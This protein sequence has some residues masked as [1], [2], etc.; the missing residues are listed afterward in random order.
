MKIK[1]KKEIR[2]EFRISEDGRL[3]IN[4]HGA[5]Q[6]SILQI[7]KNGKVSEYNCGTDQL[8]K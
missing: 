7:R 1:S 4:F 6:A 8:Y 2:K 3:Q 5:N